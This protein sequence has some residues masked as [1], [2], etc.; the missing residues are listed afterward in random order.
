MYV[1]GGYAW[2]WMGGFGGVEGWGLVLV[3]GVRGVGRMVQG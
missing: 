3:L 1:A 2:V